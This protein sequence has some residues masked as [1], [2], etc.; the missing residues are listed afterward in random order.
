LTARA[1]GLLDGLERG[2]APFFLHM[3][4]LEPHPPYFASPPYDSMVDWRDLP[5]P[6]QG[7]AGSRPSWHE[8]AR[9]TYGTDKA[10]D[11][12]VKKMLAVYYGMI[13][14]ADDQMRRL[15]D[16]M[17]RRGLMENTWVIVSSDHGDYTTWER[18]ACS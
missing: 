2:D 7:L 3:P 4:L 6:R 8:T 14:Y 10:T 11:A 18:R 1:I 9:Q 15:Y 12:D 13:A 5:L 17:D 16:E